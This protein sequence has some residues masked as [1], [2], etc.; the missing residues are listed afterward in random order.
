MACTKSPQWAVS[1]RVICCWLPS[2][3]I[4]VPKQSPCLSHSS[5]CITSSATTFSRTLSL[6]SS[7]ISSKTSLHWSH[8]KLHSQSLLLLQLQLLWWLPSNSLCSQSYYPVMAG[9]RFTCWVF[10]V[11][12]G[13]MFHNMICYSYSAR[14]YGSTVV[15]TSCCKLEDHRF[16]TRWGEWF[17]FQHA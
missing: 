5:S 16:E 6:H 15:K 2:P 9:C 1:S 7:H 13:C 10:V 3:D 12:F 4:R 8:R 11:Y 14:A 17:S